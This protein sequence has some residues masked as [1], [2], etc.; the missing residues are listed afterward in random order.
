MFNGLLENITYAFFFNWKTVIL[1]SNHP[2]T[3]MGI[4]GIEVSHEASNWTHFCHFL[5]DVF[6]AVSW[7]GLSIK[8]FLHQDSTQFYFFLLHLFQPIHPLPTPLLMSPAQYTTFCFLPL[9]LFC[10]VRNS[11]RERQIKKRDLEREHNGLYSPL[12]AR[13]SWGYQELSK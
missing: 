3:P 1:L 10:N 9:F 13:D 4:F 12:T 8:P 7:N 6:L 5:R 2:V 11:Y